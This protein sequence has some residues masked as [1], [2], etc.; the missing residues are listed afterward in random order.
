M[1]W[2]SI[3]DNM[4]PFG[5]FQKT[6]IVLVLSV[7]LQYISVS[8]AQSLTEISTLS[9]Q[10]EAESTLEIT[11]G[12][13]TPPTTLPPTTTTEMMIAADSSKCPVVILTPGLIGANIGT[14][15]TYKAVIESYFEEALESRW[16]SLNQS[17]DINHPKFLGSKN[18]PFPELVINNVTFEDDGIYEIQVRIDD[19]W[20]INIGN[21]VTLDTIGVLD[22]DDPCNSSKECDLLKNLV[23][24]SSS[25]SCVCNNESYQRNRTCYLRTRLR[26]I[27]SSS[28]AT[29]SNITVWWNHPYQDADL[30]QSYNVSL[31]AYDSSY[32]F[33][34][35]VEL[36]TNYTFES[37]FLPG[38]LYYFE[39]T[40][41][42]FLSDSAE[43]IFVKTDT[44]N[45]V[46]DILPPRPSDTNGSLFHPQ[47]LLLKLPK[48]NYN[49]NWYDITINGH[50]EYYV[51]SI[52]YKWPKHLE[53][54]TNYTIQI[55][56]YCWWSESYRRTFTYNGYIETQRVPKVT[57]PSSEISVS[58]FSKLE[59]NATVHNISNIPFTTA[60]K[61]QKNNEDI[62]I[63][64]SRYIGST[65]D[66][67]AP[68]LVISKVEYNK[69]HGQ[70]YR[71]VATNSEGS[72]V[73][74]ARINVHESFEFLESC[75]RSEQCSPGKHLTCKQYKCL[76][77]YDYYHFNSTC[78]ERY[79]LRGDFIVE[80][81]KCEATLRWRHRIVD[82]RLMT[83][84]LIRIYSL[85]DNQWF[86]ENTTSVGVV[87][88][89]TYSRCIL[90]P[91]RLYMFQIR[92]NV[93]LTE[94]YET[95]Y[96]NSYS[97]NIIL[98]PLPPGKIDRKNSIFSPNQLMLR[99]KRSGHNTFLNHYRVEI[100]GHQ[101]QTF[102]SIPKIYWTRQLTPG[103]KYNVTITAVSYGDLSHGTSYGTKE[104]EP[105]E[106]WIETDTGDKDGYSYLSFG[107][108]DNLLRGDDNTSAA[109]KSPI[110][111]YAG[112]GLE[113]GFN[114]V[115]IGSNGIMG[116]GEEFN[117]ISIHDIGADQI[118]N[119]RIVCPF[120]SDLKDDIGYV[121]YQ[122]Y[123]RGVDAENDLF[124]GK[125]S[126]IVSLQFADLPDFM[127]TWLV[128]ATWVNMTLLGATSKTV[129][130]QCLLITDGHSTF[131]VFNY[132]DV[133]LESIGNKKI[134]IG[135]QYK[136]TSVKNQYSNTKRVFQMSE[137]PGNRGVNGFWIYK[138]TT[139]VPVNKDEKKC[140]DWYIRN[141]EEN[142]YNQ[143]TSVQSPILCPCN[144]ILLRFDP[145][146]IRSRFDTINQ[147][148][149]YATM[150]VGRNTEC[151]YQMR[152]SFDDVGTLERS[153]PSAGTLLKNNPFFERRLYTIEDFNSREACCIKT[154][155]CSLFYEVRPIPLCYRRSPFNPAL[156]FGDPHIVTLDGKNYTFNGYGEYTM[157]KISKDSVQ[158]DLQART[159]L[160]TTANGTSINATI[161]SAFVAKDQTGSKLQIEMSRD[162]T[163][164]LVRVNGRDM[165]RE[166]RSKSYVFFNH[167]LTV[168][169]EN[170]TL[171]ASFLQTS[172]ILRVSLG[173]RFLISEVVVDNAYRG[174]AKG[175]MGNFDGNA[176]NEFILPNGILL[177]GNA[178]KTER[179]IYFNFGQK[180]LVNEN[181]LFYYEKGLS[182]QN[183]THPKFQPIFLDEVD[184]NKSEN[185]KKICGSN[186]SKA[187]IFDYLATGDIALAESS[188]IEEASAQSDI[189]I[190]ENESPIITGNDSIKVE[191]NKTVCMQF[192]AS[193]DSSNLPIYNL[194]KQPQNFT[195]NKT[196]GIAKWTPVSAA[197][198]ELSISVKD[199]VGAESPS[200]DVTI[201]L[202]KGCGNNG[203][204]SFDNIISSENDRFSLAVCECDIGYSG[205][206]CELDTD[207]C[208]NYPCPLQRNCTDLTPKEEIRFGR[209]YN[210]T[211]CPKGYNDI[212][213][214]C[215]DINE[216]EENRTNVCNTRTERC[217]N[218]EG[219]YL[220]I[221]LPGFRKDNGICKDIDECFEKTSGCEQICNNT[222]GSFECLC[223]PGFSLNSA[224]ATCSINAE[225]S[226]DGVPR[227][228]E[229]TCDPI[230]KKCLCPIGFHVAEDGQGCLDVNEC[231]LQPSKCLQGCYN[232]NGSFQCYCRPGFKLNDDKISCSECE[233]PYFGE[234]CSQICTCGQGMKRCDPVTGCV[235]KLGWT[236]ENCT[237]DINEC[238]NNQDTYICGNEK[239]C[240][241][242]E[243]SYTCNCKEGF[244]KNGD[245]CED[246][247]ECSDITLN[248]CADDTNCQNL[249]GNYTCNCKPGFQKYGSHCE[250][251]DECEKGIA[252]CQQIC[253]NTV[254][255]FNCECE[256]GYALDDVKRKTCEEVLDVCSLFPALNCSYG[257]MFDDKNFYKGY[258]FC[259]SGYELDFDN[260]T[261][262]DIDECNESSTCQH[263]CTNL[264][265][266]FECACATGYSLDNDGISCKD[267]DECLQDSHCEHYC[268]NTE[269]SYVCG[270]RDGYKLVNFSKCED[271]DECST[272]DT[273]CQNC[274][275]IP[276]SFHCSCFKGYVLN[277]NTISN[278]TKCPEGYYGEN[279]QEEC[280]C[281]QGSDRCDHITGCYCKP[282]W[283]GALCET[284]IDECNSTDN[285]CNSYTEECINNYG[286]FICR[287]KEGFT[288]STNGSCKDIDECVRY[289]PCEHICN[290]T[291]GNYVCSC[292][293]GYNLVNY[294]KCEDI[295]ECSTIDTGI[296]GCQ[297]CTNTPGSFHCSCSAGYAL[298]STTL[299]NCHNID[300]CK[301]QTA[302][303]ALNA[304]CSDTDGG[305]TC[306]CKPGF[307]GNGKTCTDI[308]ECVRYSPCEHICNNT[309]GGYVC[310]CRDGYNLLNFSKCEDIDECSTVDTGIDGCQNC[311]NTPG[312]FRCSCF[313]GYTLNTTTLTNCYNIDECKEQTADC[314]LN[315]TCSDT[316]GGYTCTCKSGFEGNGKICTVCP[317]F[318]YGVNCSNNCACVLNNTKLCDHVTGECECSVGWTGTNCSEDIDECKSWSIICNEP[319]FQIC[320][321]T[322]GSA[323][324]ECRYGGSD[325][326]NCVPPTPPENSICQNFRYG[327]NCSKD[328]ACVLN[329]TNS[330]HNVTGTCDC[331]EGWIGTD[332]SEDN[333]E[334]KNGLISCNESI[335]QVCVNTKGSAHCE[336]RHGGTDIS[337]CVAP[338]PPGTAD[339]NEYKVKL[340]ISFDF[341][342]TKE[343]ILRNTDKW[344]VEITSQL[345][346]FYRK[347]VQGFTRVEFL[348]LQ[349]GSV[350]V[351]HEIY[352]NGTEET[353]KVDTANSMVKLLRQDE[354]IV[355]FNQSAEVKKI[356]LFTENT[357]VDL[358]SSI[359]PCRIYTDVCSSGKTCVDSSGV[360]SCV[361]SNTKGWTLFIIIGIA[362]PL[363]M[364]TIVLALVYVCKKGSSKQKSKSVIGSENN[365][366]K[367][368]K[369]KSSRGYNNL[370]YWNSID[371]LLDQQKQFRIKR[372]TTVY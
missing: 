75:N 247:D 186:P 87:A 107:Q 340:E 308:D 252:N 133:N 54:G 97:R 331:K 9:T 134:T 129:T 57:F 138:M 239:V 366:V 153:L 19:G 220:C 51:Y 157:L 94:P 231:D 233:E 95:F 89:F 146:Y 330:C 115:R 301:E 12:S 59:I 149:C 71:C 160:A 214:K 211:D 128:K 98:E 163:K 226:C 167:K 315:A 267:I 185:A 224:T 144:G 112:D 156:N 40:S 171:A 335:H 317:N 174:C 136:K 83:D 362:V 43:T 93:S 266:S 13:S 86:L 61:W 343:N 268:N 242:L 322:E 288:N 272:I 286:S 50:L 109:L 357:S 7:L 368:N 66:L 370:S 126:K 259:P 127:A 164:M 230:E 263:N 228:C 202:C 123:K 35:S 63:T 183:F 244:Q 349:F 354:K 271:I 110:T 205:E 372:P 154:K 298:N 355:L 88:E 90:R 125:A 204:C 334:C 196:T 256:F 103:T 209:G 304:T 351:D 82:I 165:T 121:Y 24:S 219:S 347:G 216:C 55:V 336:C 312:S 313:A 212:D 188:G 76:C 264:Q 337:N 198:S 307:E 22:L 42:I 369:K 147:V 260:R 131:T 213:N 342:Y 38:Y 184:E 199:D 101:Q 104:S 344:I 74:S 161:F 170:R 175:L 325:I 302:D 114:F 278:C 117:S 306:T 21:N 283:T 191:V 16:S 85:R 300:E 14:S 148:L 181:S 60:V 67:V 116:L 53:P 118:K 265:G 276:G 44:V 28:K 341:N 225:N 39:I 96:I 245:S 122:T 323:H 258:C 49:V 238:E 251:V 106:D 130:F 15:V 91:G 26:A 47:M 236:G 33:Q 217:E 297:N 52:E 1:Q 311:T 172:I 143:L 159:D 190:I 70:Y 348:S 3:L 365:D 255:G 151:C 177:D 8:H 352:S 222:L 203:R 318:K 182:Y 359:N 168:R 269:G 210:C 275:N 249:Y 139:G 279:C 240:Q 6:F 119:R 124:L 108:S 72:W 69:D 350:I 310:S 17:I 18:I 140:F 80:T 291:D 192:N 250:D 178:T 254:G 282:G 25:Q 281:G 137:I 324:C 243:G 56:A 363:S 65:S 158:F 189:T 321:N 92:S 227:F 58:L 237:V 84:Y 221:C 326:S 111:I 257:C 248:T 10:D 320:V 327:D 284:D 206:I 180:W 4:A 293:D 197:V 36:Q 294:S 179:D 292:R 223:F 234:D 102:G 41:V 29:T 305:Y 299:T 333:D 5:F 132:I 81:N 23:C 77:E 346:T 296:D 145:R 215:E 361:N 27:F 360:A 235:C 141:K 73:A 2:T 332:C 120:W 37:S 328:C 303:C 319:I 309:D 142:I 290:N 99:W 367:N 289:S 208:L 285:P 270:C 274:T 150:I 229:Y 105:F 200:I 232:T 11:N 371:D 187:C 295:D 195:L 277:N 273:G 262:K 78:Y 100:D 280:S 48:E 79:D 338:R 353:L 176:T 155:Q 64:D 201:V 364:A 241:N 68:K 261:C 358:N 345:E 135:Y 34:T 46:V 173:V 329:N 339:I 169:W 207:A 194:L 152:G 287:C 113:A 246:I 218:S 253:I 20:C 32:N 356:F 31:R 166:F 62:N 45:L 314:A 193:D 30:V 316:D 162:K